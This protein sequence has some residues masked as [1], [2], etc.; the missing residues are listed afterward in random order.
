MDIHG[1]LSRP[2]ACYDLLLFTNLSS[3]LPS[4]LHLLPR[5]ILVGSWTCLYYALSRPGQASWSVLYLRSQIVFDK[6][7]SAT[8]LHPELYLQWSLPYRPPS[9]LTIPQ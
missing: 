9:R 3:S 8:W 7:S 2:N 6:K 1:Q 5:T 4:V